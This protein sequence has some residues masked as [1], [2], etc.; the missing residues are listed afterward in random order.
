[1]TT[2]QLPSLHGIS[3][4]SVIHS[5]FFRHAGEHLTDFNLK[6][7]VLTGFLLDTTG[8]YKIPLAVLGSV[9]MLGGC[10]IM[11][12]VFLTH[13]ERAAKTNQIETPTQEPQKLLSQNMDEHQASDDLLNGSSIA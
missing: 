10:S 9:S 5:I 4:K 8:S 11:V 13:R 6:F 3:N 12:V 2:I 7:L 1:M